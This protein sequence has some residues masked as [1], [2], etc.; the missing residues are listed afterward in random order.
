MKPQF[1]KR[2]LIRNFD[3]NQLGT[4]MSDMQGSVVS[5]YK[6]GHEYGFS[7]CG[8]RDGSL[9]RSRKCKGSRCSIGIP[10]CGGSGIKF[11]QFHTHPP[12]LDGNNKFASSDTLSAADVFHT[13]LEIH[14]D[15]YHIDLAPN[16]TKNVYECVASFGPDY[17][18][19]SNWKYEI[20][21]WDIP[22]VIQDGVMV[23]AKR[24]IPRSD[25]FNVLSQKKHIIDK[26]KLSPPPNNNQIEYFKKSHKDTS[27]M[28]KNRKVE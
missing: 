5:S 2:D 20:A 9:I 18:D 24:V 11:I 7:I 21:C 17:A 22:E 4:F 19:S 15:K 10:S 26:G 16:K 8:K 25:F 12:H 14:G 3:Y 27:K 13:S 28:Y 1:T 6:D 23:G